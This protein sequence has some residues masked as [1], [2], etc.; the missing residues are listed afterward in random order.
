M[1][2]D[3]DANKKEEIKLQ[4]AHL[5]LVVLVHGYAVVKQDFRVEND[6]AHSS[7]LGLHRQ[8]GKLP[9]CGIKSEYRGKSNSHLPKF[10][11]QLLDPE[12]EDQQ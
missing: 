12:H 1:H 6:D 2:L 5:H 7:S 4:Q 11:V 8:R 10:S 3:S 9:I